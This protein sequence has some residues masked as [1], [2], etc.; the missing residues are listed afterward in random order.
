M[1]STPV[2][3]PLILCT[4]LLLGA[5]GK[6][7]HDAGATTAA[8]AAEAAAKPP[9]PVATPTP[10]APATPVAATTASAPIDPETAL[11][12]GKFDFSAMEDGYMTDAKAQWASSATASSSYDEKPDAPPKAPADSRAW[13]ATGK[14][15]GYGWMQLSQ[16]IGFDRLEVGFATPVRAT[17]IRVV[18]L[19]SAAVE[20]ITKV[21]LVDAAGA[22]SS[23]WS[24]LSDQKKDE[25]GSRTWFVRKFDKTTQ[26]IKA[27]K[28][29]FAN[30]VYS[31][32]KEI[33]AVQL[34][35]E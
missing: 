31:G 24:G 4:A 26:P 21:E 3:T 12:Q 28:L 32:Y 29:T 15:D 11:R 6:K 7:P 9:T 19:S 8:P 35:G 22:V 18:M 17:E 34:V 25:R 30:N 33:D 13:K 27:V 14:P 5:C 2:L 16:D 10:A 23:V 1:Q 20:A